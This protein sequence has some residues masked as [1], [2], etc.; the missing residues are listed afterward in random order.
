M[1]SLDKQRII[2]T[3]AGAKVENGT[4]FESNSKAV[5]EAPSAGTW[6]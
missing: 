5:K 1:G 6:I 2:N 3:V 4:N